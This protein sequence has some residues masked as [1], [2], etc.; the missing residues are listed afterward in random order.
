VP[1]I[2]DPVPN[3]VTSELSALRAAVGRMVPAKAADNVL[4]GTWNVRDLDR[5]FDQWRSAASDSPIRDLSDVLC[6]AEIAGSFDVLAVQEVRRSAQAFRAMM[7]ALGPGWAYLVT[8]VTEG[9]PGN[10]ERLAFV[11]DTTRLRPSGLACE[12]VVAADAAG[13]PPGVLTGQFART[14]YAVSF[15]RGPATFTLVT[16]HVVYGNTSTD[17]IAE[18]TEIA[19]WLARWNASGDAWGANLIALG[20]FN[21]D[22]SGDPLYQALTSTGL[23]PPD[24]LNLVPRTVFDDPDPNAPPDH[25]HFYDQI[26]WFP[27]TAGTTMFTLGY[28]NAGMINFDTGII[29]A[30][31]TVQLSWRIS[32]HFPLWCEFATPT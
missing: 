26:A 31:S 20:D 24:P 7:S 29:P 28:R 25:R 21:I 13:I 23:R 9:N 16:L 6:I 27:S 14:P 1:A 22:R 8:D 32:D 4:I 12:L 17:R 10:N 3:D 5:V 2:G 19:D 11:F 18:L 30:D 15:A